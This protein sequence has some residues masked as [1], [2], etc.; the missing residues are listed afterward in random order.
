MKLCMAFCTSCGEELPPGSK[1]CE[2]CGAPVEQTSAPASPP[3][4]VPEP[5]VPPAMEPV[6]V[7]QPL[8]QAPPPKKPVPAM[9]IIGIL[10]VLA[11]VAAAV[12][13]VGLPALQKMQDS[14]APATP[15]ATP[16]ATQVKTQTTL[17]AETPVPWVTPTVTVRKL[18]PRYEEYYDEIYSLDQSFSYGQKE[19]FAHDLTTPP[20]FIKYNLTPDMITREKVINIGLST[21]ETILIT[22]ANPNAWFEIQVIDAGN[23]A[24]VAAKGYGKDYSDMTKSEFMV[25]NPGN[26][27]IEM[28]GS[29]VSADI[30]IMQ[31]KS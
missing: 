6:P 13:F 20:L 9:M 8:V 31:G 30:S 17:P 19:T 24:V 7:R 5:A 10:V 11:L 2:N 21:E 26:Y 15:E 22:Y 23:G 12:W 18:D 16:V 27:R 1:F 28:S 14:S 25:R 4:P 29:F 3:A